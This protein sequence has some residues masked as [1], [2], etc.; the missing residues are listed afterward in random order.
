MSPC[1]RVGRK[2]EFGFFE[3]FHLRWA[4]PALTYLPLVALLSVCKTLVCQRMFYLS[5]YLWLCL[6]CLHTL[7]PTHVQTDD[8]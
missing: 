2:Y 4:K 1:G 8:V 5:H 3:D 6:V 7:I